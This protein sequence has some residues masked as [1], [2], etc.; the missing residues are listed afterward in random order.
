M[1]NCGIITPVEAKESSNVAGIFYF[2]PVTNCIDSVQ[3]RRSLRQ[4]GKPPRY[5]FIWLR[6]PKKNSVVTGVFSFPS[7]DRVME[8]Y[9]VSE[10]WQGRVYQINPNSKYVTPEGFATPYWQEIRAVVLKEDNYTCQRCGKNNPGYWLTIHHVTPRAIGG[11]DN[12]ENLITLCNKCHDEVE[13]L[14]YL[15][16]WQIMNQ[17]DDEDSDDDNREA[18]DKW[19]GWVYGSKRRPR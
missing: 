17:F 19:Q 6:H 2:P 8:Y 14:G 3:E 12:V 16:K 10:Q 9:T 15:S 1:P 7:R 4:H 11:G 5:C 13:I 18:T